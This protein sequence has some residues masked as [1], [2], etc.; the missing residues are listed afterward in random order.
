MRE[1]SAGLRPS[2]RLP[3]NSTAPSNGRTRP[4]IVFMVVDLPQALPPSRHTSSP[5]RTSS[6]TL[7][8]PTVRRGDWPCTFGAAAW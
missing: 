3:S 4:R 7:R 8:K 1:M 2:M 6:D 5:L